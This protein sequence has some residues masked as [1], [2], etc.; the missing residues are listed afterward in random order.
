MMNL[1]LK[2]LS[3]WVVFTVSLVLAGAAQATRVEGLY[4][5]EVL[6]LQNTAAGRAEAFSLAL[7]AVLVKV[8]GQEQLPEGKAAQ[9]ANAAALVQ[10]Y[11]AM[12]GQRIEVSFDPAA[13]RRQLDAAQLPVWSAARPASLPRARAPSRPRA[14]APRS[15]G[16]RCARVGGVP[17]IRGSMTV[18]WLKGL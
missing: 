16:R 4:T 1:S 18:T 12:E 11:R 2:Q 17:V 14:R 5:A 13:L 8:T 15:E 6:L 10:Q 3:L 9:F 7:A